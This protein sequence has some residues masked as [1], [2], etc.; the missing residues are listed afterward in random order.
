VQLGTG[1]QDDE[2]SPQP[3]EDLEDLVTQTE[4][5]AM[6]KAA[7]PGGLVPLAEDKPQLTIAE[8]AEILGCQVAQVYRL[9]RKGV[10][11]KS[12]LGGAKSTRIRTVDLRRLLGLD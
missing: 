11:P 8:V 6:T 5:Q 2:P 4:R 7:S 1:R 3:A 9:I 12:P 10:L